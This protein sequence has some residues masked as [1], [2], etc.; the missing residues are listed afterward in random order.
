MRARSCAARAATKDTAGTD[1]WG[2]SRLSQRS[3]TAEVSL[4][5]RMTA[6]PVNFLR[7]AMRLLAAGW[8]EWVQ[9][10]RLASRKDPNKV[11][12]PSEEIRAYRLKVNHIWVPFHD[13]L[14]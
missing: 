7:E 1:G 6:G 13:E 3:S 8:R 10:T 9:M 11:T 2:A 4:A 12:M 5:H 14:Y